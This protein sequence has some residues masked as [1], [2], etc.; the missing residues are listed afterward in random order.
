MLTHIIKTLASF[1][2]SR[3]VLALCFTAASLHVVRWYQLRK[4]MPPGPLGLPFIGNS[5]QVP[6]VKPWRKFQAWNEHYGPV[7]SLFLG[8]TP[9]VVLGTPQAAW[10]LLDKRS[11]IYS[12]RPRFIMGGEI[13]SDNKRGLMLP[14]GEEWRK[15]RKILHSGF[16][17]RK[18][19]EY[20]PIQSLES[21]I[22]MH[23]ILT[24]PKGYER[25]IQRY[26]ASVVTSVTYGKRIDSVDEWVVRENMRAMDCALHLYSIPGK[27]IVES[28]PWLLNL[29]L[30]LQWFRKAPEAQ[31][32]R[33]VKFLMHLYDEVKTRMDEGTIADCLTSQ[34]ISISEKNGWDALDVAYAVSSPFGAGIET[35]AGTL[36]VFFLAM[37]HYPETM[38]KAQQEID[39]VIGPER[40]P[41][42]EHKDSLPYVNALINETLRW[43][44]VAALGGSPHAVT[45]DDEYHGMYIPKGSTVF[46]NLAGIMHDPGTF[47]DPDDFRPERFLETS[48][49]RLKDFTVPF[50]FGR[51]ICPGMH[52]ARNSVF[53]NI[54]RIL[55]AF[56]ILPKKDSQNRE[57]LPD[58]WD[59]SNGFNSRPISFECRI[60]PRS[61]KVVKCIEREAEMAR[62]SFYSQ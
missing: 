45:S 6:A 40:M 17:A 43:R 39:S 41:E 38:K 50:G 56:N 49:P 42:F 59:F 15:W 18:S 58:R 14:Y 3:G 8:S 7:V 13:L 27:Y 4:K 32:Q 5:H 10:D 19:D 52:L 2:F 48:D 30:C 20:Q 57:I 22:M 37:L 36:S 29:P 24:E 9:V 25:H 44:P 35:T 12:S 55:W 46:A 61:D 51:R 28:M 16:H 21:K 23:Q 60:E 54:T 1:V 34:T 47:P 26:A 62:S 11:D 33:D 31:R 53:M